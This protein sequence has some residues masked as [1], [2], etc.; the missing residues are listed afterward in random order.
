MAPRVS[1][2]VAHAMLSVS[3]FGRLGVGGRCRN[4][5]ESGPHVRAERNADLPD[6]VVPLVREILVPE[7]HS[8]RTR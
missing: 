8:F 2:G 3:R 6:N 7:L 4:R 5:R 1:R